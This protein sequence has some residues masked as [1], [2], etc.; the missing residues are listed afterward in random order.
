KVLSLCACDRSLGAVCGRSVPKGSAKPIVWYQKFEYAKDFW[1]VKSSQNIIGSVTCCP[2]CFSLYRAEALSGIVDAFSQP[3]K[4]A[5]Q[6]LVMDHGEDRWLCT[7]LMRQGW[8]LAYS[9]SARNSTH[10]PETVGEF[11][12]QR[13]RWVLSELFNMADIFL[14]VRRLVRE[15]SSFSVAFLLSLFTTLLWVIVSPATTLLCVCA[16][17]SVLCSVPLCASLP[18]AAAIF[19]GYCAVCW[20]GSQRM[21][22]MASLGLTLIMAVAVVTL[23]VFFLIYITRKIHDGIAVTFR[24]YILVILMSGYAIYAA[25]LHHREIPSL[26]YGLAYALLFP[27]IFVALPVYALSNMLDQSWGTRQV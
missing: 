15:N 27:A 6:C 25:L 23:S 4:S 18:T 3:A 19:A 13:R 17:M 9:C 20:F 26:I 7:L 10:C 24:P 11:L 16:G 12:R 14:S 5:F 21:Q 22:K 1:L 8:R 2:G